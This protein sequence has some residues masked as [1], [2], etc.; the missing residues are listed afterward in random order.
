MTLDCAKRGQIIEIIEIPDSKIRVQAIRLGMFEGAKLSCSEKI[1][2][3]PIIL[4]NRL[5]EIAIG[6]NLAR[7]IKVKLIS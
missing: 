5:Q 3:G 1:P 2:T 7:R 6:R 4:K